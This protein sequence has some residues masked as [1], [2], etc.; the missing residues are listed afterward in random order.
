MPRAEYEALIA[1]KPGLAP[2]TVVKVRPT[3]DVRK[4]NKT[5]AAYLFHL[6]LKTDGWEWIGVQN[7]TFKLADDT[8][9]TPDMIVI[10]NGQ[11]EAHEVKGF[12]RDDAKVKIKVAARLFPWVH[13][14]VAMKTKS[15]WSV[16]DV[17]P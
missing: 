9:Y 8:R 11:V 10:S 12:W 14:K 3:E 5:E 15:G 13:F 17:K 4:L 7:M 16:V 6:Q 1:R 2:G